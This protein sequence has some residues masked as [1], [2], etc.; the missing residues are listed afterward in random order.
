M[1]PVHGRLTGDKG[2]KVNV[3]VEC[4]PE[5]ARAFLGLPDVRPMQETMMKEIEQRMRQGMT[6][7]E[8]E[9]LLK[10]WLPLGVQGFEHAQKLFWSQFS[11]GGSTATSDEKTPPKA[12]AR[13]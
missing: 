9:A 7:M 3:N 1:G 5:E 10:V 6:A 11:G 4:T 2:M 8:P 12:G 13:T